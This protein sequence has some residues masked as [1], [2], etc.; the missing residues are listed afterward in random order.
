MPQKQPPARMARSVAEAMVL[1]LPVE[2]EQLAV[3]AVAFLLEIVEMDEAQRGRIDAI[4]QA[5]FGAWAIGKEMSEMAVAIAGA[6]LGP[7]HA[8]A[9]VAVFD[10]I[11]RLD[12]PGEAR[13]AGAAVEFVDRGEERLAGHHVDV[14]PGLLVVPIGVV[15]GPL[16]PVLLGHAEL[17]GR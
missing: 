10:D 2:C 6:N 4:A 14:D 3:F 7:D 17:L 1:F 9:G 13:P 8:V 12:R 15:E 16:R 11:L 5:A